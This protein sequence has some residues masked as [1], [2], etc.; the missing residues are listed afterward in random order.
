MECDGDGVCR[1]P[2]TKQAAQGPKGDI[3]PLLYDDE[4]TATILEDDAG[5]QQGAEAIHGKIVGLYFS[6]GWCPP[7]R[8]FSPELSRFQAAHSDD[9]AV[10]FISCDHSEAEMKSFCAGKGFLRVPFGSEARATIQ[11]RMGVSMLPTLVIVDVESGEVLTDWGR[12]AVTRNPDGCVAAW[13]R[14]GHGCSWMQ[15]LTGGSCSV[16]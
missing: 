4:S 10:I 13:R 11:A 12:A 2:A 1:L 7:C 5:V 16:Q 6:A 9:F 14:G 3:L 8:K 15:F